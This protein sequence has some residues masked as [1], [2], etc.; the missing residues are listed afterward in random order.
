[1]GTG[2]PHRDADLGIARNHGT[3][4]DG[5]LLIRSGDVGFGWDPES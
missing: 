5:R 4:L 3:S 1:L 2:W